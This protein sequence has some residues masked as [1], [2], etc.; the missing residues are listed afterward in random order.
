MH[1]LGGSADEWSGVAR[2]LG[3]TCEWLF[4]DL[5]GF[6]SAAS[7][8]GYT[9][10]AMVDFLAQAL[11][12]LGSADFVLLGHSMSGKVAIV[13]AHLAAA[14][15]Q[16]FAGLR[17]IVLAASSPPS[18][19]PIPDAKRQEMLH[20]L[21]GS[22]DARQK[23]AE[24]Y[25]RKNISRVLA[26]DLF[27]LAVRDVLRASPFGWRAWLESG[28]REDWAQRVGLLHLPAVVIAG[29]KDTGL[30]PDAQRQYVLPH[31][32]G[33]RLQEIAGA[34]HLLP[35]EAP[36][37]IAQILAEFLQQLTL[38]RVGANALPAEY[39]ALIESGR[40]SAATRRV[41]LERAS[42]DD[43][44][45]CPAVLSLTEL[46]LL[47]AVAA[48]ILPQEGTAV[49]LAAR[50]DKRL[51]TGAGKGWR[52]AELPEDAEACRR[53]L[54]TLDLRSQ[55]EFGQSFLHLQK[56]AQDAILLSCKEGSGAPSAGFQAGDGTALT[57]V[58]MRRWFEDLC[59]ELTGIYVAHP[60]ALAALGYS[61][62][63]DGARSEALTG[64][65]DL[66]LGKVEPWEP[67]PASGARHRP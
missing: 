19:E 18:P 52:Y 64:F 50:M 63:A 35:L 38:E 57:P 8:T 54:A 48:R 1:F 56:D 23:F 55:A 65:V 61:G 29:Q 36:E 42:A 58:Q 62:I 43:P 14:G 46:H 13:A 17:G 28:S 9:V 33:A 44:D 4:L 51:G 16:R 15:D 5:P 66:G 27:A 20:G 37:E 22:E 32:P 30:G 47:R 6:G 53:G 25:I 59:A 3:P 10:D 21:E 60:A 67:Q 40:V 41:L 49:D 2:M 7:A 26:P 39:L 45:Y 34:G 12:Q 31:L 11:L 24:S